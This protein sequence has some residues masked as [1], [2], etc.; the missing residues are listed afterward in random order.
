VAD[1][2]IKGGRVVDPAQKID[3]VMD[4]LIK[5]G[6]IEKV[7]KDIKSPGAEV[8]DASGCI[9]TP[10]FIDLHAHFRQPGWKDEETIASGAAA[11]VK[12]GYTTVCVMP[13]TEPPIDNETGVVYVRTL[14]KEA[15]L[16][17]VLP[18]AAATV[19]R[20]GEVPT[21]MVRLKKYGACAVSDDGSS[22]K[23]SSVM[24]TV[25]TYA[26]EA[27]LVM[28]E[29]AEDL[30]LTGDGLMH[31][32]EV[33]DITGIPG[34]PCEAES[35]VVE[36]DCALAGLTGG[37][38]HIAHLSTLQSA[39]AVKHAQEKG[40][41]VTA[42]VAPHH[43][44]LTD[45]LMKTYDTLYK[46]NPPL[47]TAEINAGLIDAL[48]E[49]V[50]CAIATDHAPHRAE[51][52]ELELTDAPSGFQ[53]IECAFSVMYTKLV[54]GGMLELATLIER[55][56]AGPA[57]VLGLDDRGSF[58]R[59]KRGDVTVIDL[60]GGWKV[61]EGGYKSLSS[62]CPYHGWD[63]KGVVKKTVVAGKVV[64]SG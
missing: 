32:G 40:W 41:K 6:V 10:G 54:E 39:D 48:K 57:K 29:H 55:L 7:G 37:R 33:S 50:I 51:E 62:N 14:S 27:G 5:N 13:N 47:R 52:K 63:V 15:G 8:V 21:E 22:V 2:I 4:V 11:A 18:V 17:D 24:R 58:A 28:M 60:K 59:G 34:V 1:I 36:R 20:K 61:G 31:E 44:L 49:G 26:K 38:L 16:C 64:Y 43:L 56:T 25:L 46:V 45:E 30:D 53:S 42:E 3:A 9:V 23:N 12:G 19:G 35:V